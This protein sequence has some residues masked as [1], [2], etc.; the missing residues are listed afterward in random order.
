M[1]PAPRSAVC[2]KLGRY[3][4][5]ITDAELAIEIEDDYQKAFLRRAAAHMGLADFEEA[6]RV[7]CGGIT[8]PFLGHSAG[9]HCTALHCTAHRVF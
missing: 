9:T 5:A 7:R 6:I 2:C 8:Q 3:K 4:D 1:L